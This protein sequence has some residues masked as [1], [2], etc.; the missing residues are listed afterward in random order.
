MTSASNAASAWEMRGRRGSSLVTLRMPAGRQGGLRLRL[1][2]EATSHMKVVKVWAPGSEL[3]GLG[4]RAQ[5]QRCGATPAP[6]CLR[7]FTPA[8]IL[9]RR[10][11]P[12]TPVFVDV[13]QHVEAD[14]TEVVWQG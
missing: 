5:A 9:E 3:K 12:A 10:A 7:S 4:L 8:A 13:K 2:G 1:E 14:H 11:V 6:A